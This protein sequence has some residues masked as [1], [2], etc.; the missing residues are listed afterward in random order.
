MCGFGFWTEEVLSA[1]SKWVTPLLLADG[2]E[3]QNRK[4]MLLL[5]LWTKLDIQR[6]VLAFRARAVIRIFL[7]GPEV[8]KQNSVSLPLL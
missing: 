5:T 1:G 4:S 3:K 2:A 6:A 8:E 7:K